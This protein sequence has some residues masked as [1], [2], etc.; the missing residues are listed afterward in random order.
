MIFNFSMLTCRHYVGDCSTTAQYTSHDAWN[1][2]RPISTQ[3]RPVKTG[4]PYFLVHVL[5]LFVTGA[6]L[7]FCLLAVKALGVCFDKTSSVDWHPLSEAWC[8]PNDADL[9]ND[10]NEETN[11]GAS[12]VQDTFA[13]RWNNGR[14]QL[15]EVNYGD[16]IAWHRLKV[17]LN[18]WMGLLSGLWKVQENWF[19]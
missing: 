4:L 17:M 18:Y 6:C 11:I 7:C 12:W 3:Q 1:V 9:P 8:I 16:M 5:P 15:D 19:T 10:I 13:Y 14:F 2:L